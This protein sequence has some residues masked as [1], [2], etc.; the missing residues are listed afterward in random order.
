MGVRAGKG[1]AVKVRRGYLLMRNLTPHDPPCH[2]KGKGKRKSL[3]CVYLK[4]HR[5]LFLY[6]FVFGQH[7]LDR[8]MSDVTSVRGGATHTSDDLEGAT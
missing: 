6:V 3:R 8:L 7:L 5:E 4:L 1:V 2:A